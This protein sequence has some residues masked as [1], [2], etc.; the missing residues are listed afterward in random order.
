MLS[1]LTPGTDKL[2]SGCVALVSGGLA[3]LLFAKTP[4][5]LLA[6]DTSAATQALSQATGALL[7]SK[8]AT[9]EAKVCILGCWHS[10]RTVLEWPCLWASCFMST[11]PELA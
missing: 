9:E 2:F 4:R 7:R 1:R 10:E 3:A 5:E 11:T 6:L 8:G